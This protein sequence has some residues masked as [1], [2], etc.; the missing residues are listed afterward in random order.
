MQDILD[1][2]ISPTVLG[3]L[4]VGAPR[5]A[6]KACDA[7]SRY[8]VPIAIFVDASGDVYAYPAAYST[9]RPFDEMVGIY[10]PGAGEAHMVEDLRAAAAVRH[11]EMGHQAGES[12]SSPYT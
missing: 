1:P 7:L 11:A 4:S 8:G 3:P 12:G 9:D 6:R 10:A 5:L 2:R